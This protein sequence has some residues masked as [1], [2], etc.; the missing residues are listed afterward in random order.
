MDA[1]DTAGW[2]WLCWWPGPSFACSA[3]DAGRT[4][5]IAG[6]SANLGLGVCGGKGGILRAFT[7]GA[8][9][10][11]LGVGHWGRWR[12]SLALAASLAGGVE[13]MP[14]SG[15]GLAWR[16]RRSGGW[17]VSGDPGI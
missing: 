13:L 16:G 6:A 8:A 3:V 12:A 10:V 4:D 5:A 9:L 1:L 15:S 11:M 2:P 7:A 14:M 17:G